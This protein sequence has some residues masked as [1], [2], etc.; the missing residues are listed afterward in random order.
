M[1]SKHHH[2]HQIQTQKVQP[3]VLPNQQVSPVKSAGKGGYRFNIKPMIA[4]SLLG[5]LFES[6]KGK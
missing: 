5:A 2:H 4:M 3:T 1:K 6:L